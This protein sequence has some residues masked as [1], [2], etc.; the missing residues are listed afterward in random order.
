MAKTAPRTILLKGRGIRIELPAGGAITPGHI[1]TRNSSD[2]LIVNDVASA[3][4]GVGTPPKCVAVE[5]EFLTY[6]D[7]NTGGIDTAY[8]SGDFVQAEYLT[9]GMEINALVA[10]GAAAIAKG[11]RVMVTNAGTMLTAASGAPVFGQAL[12]AVDNSGGGSLARIKV[13]VW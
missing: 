7:P 6:K 4:A 2:Q 13:V 10:A 12:E 8:A 9:P 1:V 5:N 11:A 3:T